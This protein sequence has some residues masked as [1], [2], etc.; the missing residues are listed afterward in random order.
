MASVRRRPRRR[1]AEADIDAV[2]IHGGHGYLLDVFLSPV[3]NT[4][5]DEWGGSLERRARL[6][7]DVI[8]HRC[9]MPSAARSP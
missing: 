6:L 2:E 8:H 4:R 7:C 3:T 1:A 5:D 9:A